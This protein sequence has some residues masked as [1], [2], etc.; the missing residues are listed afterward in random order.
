[1]SALK[2]PENENLNFEQALQQLESIVSSMENGNV[3]L[4]ALVS[5]FEQGDSLLKYCNKQLKDAELKIQKLKENTDDQ[6]EN[7]ENLDQQNS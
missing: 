3:P 5:Q 1:M 2:K 4:E 7:F 6:F